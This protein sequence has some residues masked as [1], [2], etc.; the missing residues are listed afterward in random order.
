MV[1]VQ[2]SAAADTDDDVRTGGK[3]GAEREEQTCAE[4]DETCA[5]NA[6]ASAASAPKAKRT[7]P[8]KVQAR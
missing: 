4:G 6:N 1:P 2:A 8:A 3:T 5:A 7:K